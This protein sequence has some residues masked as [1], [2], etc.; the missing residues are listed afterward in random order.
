M[1]ETMLKFSQRVEIMYESL[2]KEIEEKEW[3]QLQLRATEDALKELK[4]N[5]QNLETKNVELKMCLQEEK[6]E[7]QSLLWQLQAK[8]ETWKS[9]SVTHVR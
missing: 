6:K 9:Y 4:H 1:Y 8:D 5:N 2:K 7:K 3:L